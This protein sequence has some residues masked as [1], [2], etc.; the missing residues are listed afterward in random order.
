[1]T[2]TRAAAL[3]AALAAVPAAAIAQPPKP[4]TAARIE[5]RALGEDGQPVGDIK[6]EDLSLKVNGKP[7][8][9]QSLT[10]YRAVADT[11]AVS[12][13]PLPPPYSTNVAGEHGRVL[14]LLLDDDSISPG[15]ESQVKDAV[16]LLIAE[17]TPLDR[18][19]V[20]STLGAI[21]VRPGSDLV[22]V[23]SAVDSFA[24]RAG[25]TESE[26]ESKCRTKRVLA[27]LGTMLSVSAGTSTT[28]VIFSSGASVP[29]TKQVQ[30]G[31][32]T[33]AG[34]SDLCPVEPS[35][36][37]NIGGLTAA[38]AANVY[39]FQMI[40][41]LA[42]HVP[43]LD[44]GYE[45]LAGVTGGQLI[46]L[47]GNAQPGV[48]RLLRETSAYYVVGFAP[49]AGERSGQPLRVE[50]K[51][52]RDK[53][54]L[55]TP[56]SLV[57]PKEA[58]AKGAPAPK[59]MLRVATEY[60]DLPLRATSYASRMSPGSE[61]VKVV[62]LFE[63]TEEV[64]LSA[65]TVG[66]YDEKGTLKKQWT[67]TKDDLAKKLVRAD[68]QAAPGL[69]RLRVAA[70]D[71]NGRAGTTDYDLKAETVR[72]DPLTLSALVIGTQQQGAS[73]FLPRLEFT[74]EPVALGLLE[75][76][77]VP[78]G[79]AVSVVLD[80][81]ASSDGV[82]LA[83]AETQVGKGSGDDARMALGG[84]DIGSLPPGDYLMRAVVSLNGKPV[85]RVMRTIRK[86]K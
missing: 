44:V 1:M 72:A 48:S 3:L 64:P 29:E 86:A 63:S 18:I 36:F 39:L 58:A 13:A 11:P 46:R 76:Y 81:A 34:T 7:R 69:Y 5:F 62:A 21:N 68:L 43:A 82:A 54:K 49:E 67:A 31:S 56:P 6:A 70:V 27:A 33:A 57:L 71:A 37:D 65:A 4:G 45:S 24:G 38:A 53:V 12:S 23:R 8:Q 66:L 51:S 52:T 10:L 30:V 15:R 26:S 79:A 9:I 41:G 2:A 85:G 19:G 50:L 17:L 74:K 80:V 60:R 16:R 28:V 84:F 32:R 78:A 40:D 35:D 14:Y 61:E 47:Q 42:V 55:R 77:G 22:K 59:D 20:L 75:I 73:G 25:T 83:T